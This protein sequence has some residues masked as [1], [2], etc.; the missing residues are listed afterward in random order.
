MIAVMLQKKFRTNELDN[1]SITVIGNSMFPTYK[2]G[3]KV[4]IYPINRIIKV[5]DIVLYTH[6]KNSLTLHRIYE[7][8]YDEFG[9]FIYSTKG[10]NNPDVDPYSIRDSN[11]VGLVR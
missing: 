10:D 11:I 5:G 9:C 2:D 4:K 8:R 6:L 3:D 7:I 1:I